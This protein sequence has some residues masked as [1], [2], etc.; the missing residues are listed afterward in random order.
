MNLLRQYILS[1]T[2]AA[3]LCTL[4]KALTDAWKGQKGIVHFTC[5]LVMLCAVLA[6]I[7]ERILPTDWELP[8]DPEAGQRLVQ[9]A[10]TEAERSYRQNIEALTS[11]YIEDKGARNGAAIEAQVKLDESGLPWEVQITGTNPGTLR[12]TLSQEITRDLGIPP[13]RQVWGP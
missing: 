9:E 12:S 4:V 13:E 11:A 6:P 8:M 10:Q 2:A 1:V 7:R 3:L 5:G